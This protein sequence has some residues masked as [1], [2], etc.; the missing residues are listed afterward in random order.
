MPR[1]FH[2]LSSNLK[3]L[4]TFLLSPHDPS[5]LV[6]WLFNPQEPFFSSSKNPRK[7][8]THSLIAPCHLAA[9]LA[10][11]LS[12]YRH[13]PLISWTFFT[14]IFLP[15]LPFSYGSLLVSLQFAGF[16]LVPAVRVQLLPVSFRFTVFIRFLAN[17]TL[18]RRLHMV[19]RWFHPSSPVS[20][21]FL[22]LAC[23]SSPVSS[24]FLPFAYGSFRSL[25]VLAHF[26]THI[27]PHHD[28]KTQSHPHPQ[29]RS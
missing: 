17:S 15:F 2:P 11:R 3:T 4:H 12:P 18:V 21:W 1:I 19:H 26:T 25:H 7:S 10:A 24:R 6:L 23:S 27:F 8:H 13:S 16:I 5:P 20:S 28:A 22:L 14:A 29:W 9:H